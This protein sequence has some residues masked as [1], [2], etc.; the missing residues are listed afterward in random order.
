MSTPGGE[1]ISEMTGNGEV[2]T[3][4]SVDETKTD[5]TS[6]GKMNRR[7]GRKERPRIDIDP[8]TIAYDP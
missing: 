4:V 1:V 5:E 2:A 8:A 6:E 3:C 7:R